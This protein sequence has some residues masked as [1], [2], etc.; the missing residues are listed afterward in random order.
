MDIIV[1]IPEYLL[2]Q[3][4]ERVR[5]REFATRCQF[6]SRAVKA[7]LEQLAEDVSREKEV[8]VTGLERAEQQ[9]IK[10]SR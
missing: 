5:K 1:H 9:I 3:I 8:Q 7:Y 2:S 6:I 10:T 4:D